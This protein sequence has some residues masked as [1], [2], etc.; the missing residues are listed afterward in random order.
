MAKPIIRRNGALYSEHRLGR[1]GVKGERWHLSWL[2]TTL[3]D[4][5]NKFQIQNVNPAVMPFN[6]PDNHRLPATRRYYRLPLGDNAEVLTTRQLTK[7]ECYE[8][9]WQACGFLDD[10][11]Y[12][13]RGEKMADFRVLLL[14]PPGEAPAYPKKIRSGNLLIPDLSARPPFFLNGPLE[15]DVPI[16]RVRESKKTRTREEMAAEASKKGIKPWEEDR[17]PTYTPYI[18]PPLPEPRSVLRPPR[19]PKRKSFRVSDPPSTVKGD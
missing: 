8:A 12:V 13:K 15:S 2:Y 3:R 14:M 9:I 11:G 10:A 1:F 5:E 7:A 4:D 18:P 17:R 16:W 6:I 19:R